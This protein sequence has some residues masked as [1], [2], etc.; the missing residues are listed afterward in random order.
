MQLREN[1]TIEN[2]NPRHS[3]VPMDH[4]ENNKKILISRT[5]CIL[6]L[7]IFIFS[8]VAVGLLVFNFA[9]CPHLNENICDN[10]TSY[11]H[12][13]PHPNPPEMSTSSLTLPTT[14]I[15]AS[16]AAGESSTDVRLPRSLRPISYELKLV[17]FL[18]VDNF[19]FN[20]D[21]KIIFQVLEDCK[22]ITLHTFQ[23]KIADDDVFIAQ[24]PPSNVCQQLQCRK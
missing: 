1:F 21:V 24:E 10:H 15:P 9:V 23:L 17:P 22:N 19:T 11:F 7:S 16:N 3:A 13:S 5:T 12:L 8:L 6:L 20:G 4:C 18:I 2:N 14:K